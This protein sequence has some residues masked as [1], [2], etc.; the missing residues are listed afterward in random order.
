MPGIWDAMAANG[1]VLKSKKTAFMKAGDGL[2]LKLVASAEK[3]R[4][5]AGNA[6]TKKITEIK[7]ASCASTPLRMS[8]DQ[9]KLIEQKVTPETTIIK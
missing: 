9:R 8:V 6:A 1:L 2:W 3:N 5:S 7:L 4:A